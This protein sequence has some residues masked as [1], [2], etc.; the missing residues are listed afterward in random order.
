MKCITVFYNVATDDEIIEIIEKAGVSEYSK[1]PRCQ[2]KGNVSGPRFDDHVWPG[3]NNAIVMIL[4]DPLAPKVMA[5]LQAFRNGHMGRKTG[6]FAYQT[7]V[8]AVLAPP[9]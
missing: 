5:A 2:G 1:I 3:F 9:S 4:D 8:E 7:A 6:I